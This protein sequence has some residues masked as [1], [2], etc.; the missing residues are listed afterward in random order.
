MSA[1]FLFSVTMP[2]DKSASPSAPAMF[3]RFGACGLPRAWGA[4]DG[5]GVAVGAA[6]GVGVG[7]NRDAIFGTASHAVA[8]NANKTNSE[9]SKA[10]FLNMVASL[11]FRPH[12]RT[13]K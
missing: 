5:A 1:P 12:Y 8:L 9:L 6:V 7:R 13:R 11:R 3:P 4:A 10:I 2:P